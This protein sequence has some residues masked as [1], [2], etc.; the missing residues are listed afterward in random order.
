MQLLMESSLFRPQTVAKLDSE[1]S[2]KRIRKNDG[3]AAKPAKA[4]PKAPAPKASTNG[5][6]RNGKKAAPTSKAPVTA[7][8]AEEEEKRQKRLARF[9][10]AS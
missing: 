6:A 2:N 4:Q 5:N 9:N 10:N 7:F 8:S 3:G 1:L